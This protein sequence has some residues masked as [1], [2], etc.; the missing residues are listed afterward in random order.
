[1][2]TSKKN[3]TVSMKYITYDNSGQ[4]YRVR[5][6][7]MGQIIVYSME[8][9]LAIRDDRLKLSQSGKININANITFEV[10][11]NLWLNKYCTTD[12]ICTKDGYNEDINRSCQILFKKKMLDI[13]PYHIN[14]V[15]K[16]MV[17]KGFAFSTIK[18]TRAVLGSVF[19]SIRDNGFIKYDRLPTD[20]VKLPRKNTIKYKSTPRRAFNA[21]TLLSLADAADDYSRNDLQCQKM[22]TAIL[23]L[24]H[25]G[26]RLSELL[27]LCKEDISI[28]DDKKL[29]IS[30][31]RTVHPIKRTSS[32]YDLTWVIGPT[33]STTSIRTIFIEDAKI[34]AMVRLLLNLVHSKALYASTEYDF[35]LCTKSGLPISKSNFTKS[36]I[37]I[38]KIAGTDIRIHEI[39]HSIATLMAQAPGISYNNAAAFLGHSLTVFMKYY[40]H[41]D[42]KGLEDC[43]GA[44]TK[45][46]KPSGARKKK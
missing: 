2:G 24:I 14:E 42:N 30:I 8:E 16:I 39:R 15:L 38:R 21:E 44:I 37:E 9:A 10:W 27:A 12:N 23:L 46:L 29:S 34:V 7:G 20:G 3:D 11:F 35:L 26:M 43:S 32:P 33:K 45:A 6:P 40:V 41:A 1:M 18:R 22:K 5:V 28:S 13:Q 19:A 31:T 4:Y 25:T 36:F 17:N